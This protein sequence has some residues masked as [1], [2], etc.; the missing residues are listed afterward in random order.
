METNRK[1]RVLFVGEASCLAT[2]FSTYWNEVIKRLHS[3]DLF[4]I[5]EL[6]SYLSEGDPRIKSISWK[7]Y[8]VMPHPNDKE[9]IRI[10]QSDIENQF[11]KW[12]FDEACLEFKPDIVLSI[13]DFW[14][15]I[16][17]EKSPYRK[18][19]KH[20]WLQTID[21]IPQRSLWLD[22]YKR[23][24][25]C[26]TYTNWAMQVMKKDGLKGTNMIAVAS[27]GADI[28]TFKPPE[29]KKAHKKRMGIDPNSF[30]VG[31][32][33][34]NQ[35]RKLFYDLIEAFSM[36]YSKAKNKGQ[37]EKTN[38]TFLYLHTSYPD[39]GYDIGRAIREF[40]VGNRVIMTYMC[41]SCGAVFPSFFQGSMTNCR[42]CKQKTAHPP[43]ANASV[44]REVLANIM[45]LF[46]LGVQY[47]VCEGYSMTVSEQNAC[48]VPVMCVKYSGLEDHLECS[49]NI[50]IKVGRFF[51]ESV[52]ETEQK[53]ALPDNNSFVEEFDK[54][55]KI[56]EDKRNAI[57]K[58]L[59]SYTRENVSVYGQEEKL[60]KY[61]WDRTAAIWKNVINETEIL[62]QDKTWLDNNINY[63]KPDMTNANKKTDNMEF[64]NW[65]LSN[66]YNRKDLADTYFA[67]EWCNHLNAGFIITGGQRQ[68]CNRNF[69]VNYF[70][71]LV[72]KNNIAEKRRVD[73]LAKEQEMN[74][75]EIAIEVF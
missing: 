3:Q 42:S 31:M 71:D 30:I 13:R 39:A 15:D 68:N 62:D 55:L 60:P 59:F 36:W 34:R 46:D 38:K 7:F 2:G 74:K 40:N 6:G 53:R 52:I 32:V 4:E 70:L 58:E 35:K 50:P 1:K 5:A 72:N 44:P 12:K 8:P 10:Y 73:S 27:P 16:F 45:Q 22:S 49:Q 48:G 18:S 66:V 47:T 24:D 37:I 28:D 41:S 51:Y 23:C 9:G 56:S 54:F 67:K 33:S 63:I 25:G 57:S 29:D 14:M 65:V 75:N 17:I 69:V 21:G 26:L 11:G 64:I 43:N 61:S 19:F 20:I